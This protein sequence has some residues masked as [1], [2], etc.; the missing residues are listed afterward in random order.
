MHDLKACYRQGLS[1]RIGAL[2]A[3]R[4]ALRAKAPEAAATI[5]RLAH[6]LRGSGG[7]YGFPEISAAARFVEEVPDGLL[8]QEVDRLLST[9]RPIAAVEGGKAGILVV[10]DDPDISRAVQMRLAGPNREIFPAGSIAAAEQIL[11]EHEV[12]LVVLDLGLPDR[13]GRSLL[14]RLRERPGLAALPII[15]MSGKDRRTTP[16]ECF[17]L[18]ADA[19]FEKPVDLNTLAAAV[20]T[21]LQRTAEASCEARQDSM[22]GLPNRAAFRE[23]CE[24]ARALAQRNREPLSL[25]ILDLDRFKS[26]ND[27]HGHAVGD[28]VLRRAAGVLGRA[29]RKGDLLARWGGEE[30]VVLLPATPRKGAVLCLERALDVMRRERYEGKNGVT[31]TV[32]FS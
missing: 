12:A 19:Y 25:G 18:G 26:V 30:F 10:E 5:R 24:R 9:L 32:T 2:E 21:R 8:D 11:E 28:E 22:T 15:V 4:K 23:A 14:I 16:R 17:A 13:D 20:A 27:M 3:A 7:T 6:A 29:L 31:F 1:A